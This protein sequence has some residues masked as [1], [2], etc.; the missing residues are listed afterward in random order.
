MY[1]AFDP[2]ILLNVDP[3]DSILLMCEMEMIY[4]SINM[5]LVK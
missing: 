4:R 5:E 1:V 2:E 3:K